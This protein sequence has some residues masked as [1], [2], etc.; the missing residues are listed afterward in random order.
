MSESNRFLQRIAEG[1]VLCAEGY[2]FELERRGYL[3][4]GAFVP[5]VVSEHPEVVRQLHLEFVRA[6]SDVVEALT[7]YAHRE[8]M[9]LV[10]REEELEPMNRQAIRIAKEVAAETGTLAAGNICNTNIY[11]PNDPETVAKVKAIYA[12][13]MEWIADEG[14][15]LVIAETLP[16]QGE[17][18]L[19]LDAVVKTGLPAVVTLA[20][21]KD[22]LTREGFSPADTCKALEGRGAAVVGLNCA[23]GP[24]TMLPILEE[25]AAVCTIPIAALPVPF[26]THTDEPT[27]QSLT[28]PGHGHPDDGRPFPV[29]L[30]SHT[31]TRTDIARFTAAAKEIG[32]KYF[33]ICC[34]AGPHHIRAMAEALGR[35]PES[36]KYSADMS[37]HYALGEFEAQLEQ[38]RS[39]TGN[40]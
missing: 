22:G 3:Q 5:E 8:K 30:D 21:H 40:L 7:Y 15:D 2:L 27:F 28:D 14:V 24:D 12:E 13:Q 23:R 34:G 31:C 11:D 38:D 20:I 29:N 36:S 4:A 1:D 6:G 16:W 32:V 19:A 25:I 18:E 10:G 37:K 9:R 26:R 39:F 33:G 17:A 35:H